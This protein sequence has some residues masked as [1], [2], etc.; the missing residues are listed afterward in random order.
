MC[1]QAIFSW[2]SV[3]RLPLQYHRP[4][5]HRSYLL[6]CFR[7]S[8]SC[9][10]SSQKVWVFCSNGF[11]LTSNRPSQ[12]IPFATPACGN[13][14][15]AFAFAGVGGSALFLLAWSASF[16]CECA[17]GQQELPTSF[18]SPWPWPHVLTWDIGTLTCISSSKSTAES[19]AFFWHTCS[20]WDWPYLCFNF[21]GFVPIHIKLWIPSKFFCMSLLRS[22]DE[23]G[24]VAN[25]YVLI[26]TTKRHT[27]RTD[28][29]NG[30]Y[31]ICAV[32]L[33]YRLC[34]VW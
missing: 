19:T 18:L 6:L 24:H 3:F 27:L 33:F 13:G 28:L 32:C 17:A 2:R 29:L 9:L 12:G 20:F 7:W 1:K 5:I 4:A 8:R 23:V 26:S 34:R 21:V 22:L 15:G 11:S 10:P 30:T 14:G 31:F 16:S 25:L